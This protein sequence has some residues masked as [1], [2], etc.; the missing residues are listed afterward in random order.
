MKEFNIK[1]VHRMP[2]TP[3]GDAGNVTALLTESA[4]VE[5]IAKNVRFV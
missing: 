2:V 1:R 5:W 4:V 3:P